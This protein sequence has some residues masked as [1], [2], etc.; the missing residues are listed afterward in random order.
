[1]ETRFTPGPWEAHSG[2][3]YTVVMFPGETTDNASIVICGFRSAADSRLIAQAPALYE[4]LNHQIYRTHPYTE[5]CDAC[6][7]GI[8]ALKLARGEE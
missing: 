7:R 5:S 1:M 2:E 6:L 3:D 8:Q 4:A